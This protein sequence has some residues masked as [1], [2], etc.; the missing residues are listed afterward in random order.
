MAAL[1][2]ATGS[3]DLVRAIENRHTYVRQLAAFHESHDLLL[4]PTTATPPPRIGAFDAPA[5]VRAV[6]KG[7]LTARAGGLLRFTPI[8]D[9][10][11]TQNL[12][13]VPYTQLANLTGRPAMSVPLHW[14]ADGLPIGSQ[15]VGRLG[16]DGVLL[17]L[18]AQLEAA[19]AW[20]DR[21]A[22]VRNEQGPVAGEG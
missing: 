20:G 16:S 6:Q 13:W 3:V 2:R 22:P 11:I 17:R 12:G 19:R 9:Q 4:T 8:V 10:M 1:G 7:L 5:P 14:T 21:R 15:F 18:A